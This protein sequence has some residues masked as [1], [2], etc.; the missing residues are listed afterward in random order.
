M[1]IDRTCP[2][3]GWNYGN[4]KVLGVDMEPY[5]DSTA[6]ALLA[7]GAL[8]DDSD[9]TRRSMA[10]LDTM[11]EQTHSGLTFSLSILCYREWG[12]D[13][14]ELT[15]LL[16]DTFQRTGFLDDVRSL[17]LAALALAEAPAALIVNGT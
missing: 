1:I 7:L 12:R 8:R 15:A 9:E 11:L 3:G 17:G 14:S 13:T 4:K 5:P 6:A 2:G 10:A 16:V